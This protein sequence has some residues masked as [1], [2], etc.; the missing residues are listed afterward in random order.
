MNLLIQDKTE[1]FSM[2]NLNFSI[3]QMINQAQQKQQQQSTTEFLTPSKHR[4]ME[5]LLKSPGVQ[6][7]IKDSIKAVIKKKDFSPKLFTQ[8]KYDQLDR[9]ESPAQQMLPKIEKVNNI[10]VLKQIQH[11]KKKK[12]KTYP[13]IYDSK[14]P[15][16][17]TEVKEIESFKILIRKVHADI[18]L[19]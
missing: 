5:Q 7:L 1:Q 15:Q 12:C 11:V 4:S 13:I 10:H 18:S 2:P 9:S 16:Q 6:E 14:Q 19:G 8:Y 3:S 17:L